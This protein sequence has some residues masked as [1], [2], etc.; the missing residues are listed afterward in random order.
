MLLKCASKVPPLSSTKLV[1]VVGNAE[2][3]FEKLP[4]IDNKSLN[5]R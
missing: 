1:Q 3:C 4:E 5:E 2:L